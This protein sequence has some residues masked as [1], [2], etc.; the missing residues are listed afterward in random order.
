MTGPGLMTKMVAMHI[1]G[2]NLLLKSQKSFDLETWHAASG[3]EVLQSL[4]K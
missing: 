3:M 2:K 4:C 1:Y